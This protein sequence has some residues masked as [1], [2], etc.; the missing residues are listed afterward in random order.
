MAGFDVVSYAEEV[1]GPVQTGWSPHRNYFRVYRLPLEAGQSEVATA[2]ADLP[3]RWGTPEL[4]QYALACERLHA[5]HDEATA[6]LSDPTR[7]TRHRSSVEHEHHALVEVVR[8]RLHGAPA[9][10]PEEVVAL[11]RSAR[12]RWSRPDVLAALDAVGATAR[13]P[14]PMQRPAPPKRWPQLRKHLTDLPHGTLWDYLSNTPELDGVHTTVADVETRRQR[15]RVSRSR[16]ADAERSVLMLVRLWVREP[17]GLAAALA[18]ELV[19]DL[20]AAAMC[21]YPAVRDLVEPARCAAA[22]L[23]S[24]PDVVAYAAWVA[25]D[26]APWTDAYTAAVDEH[27]LRDALALLESHP[28]TESWRGVRDELRATI[29]RL[30]AELTWAGL[31]AH[32]A[33]EDA[34]AAYLLTG[35]QMRDPATTEGLRRCPAAPP[36]AV[37]AAVVDGTDVVVVWRPSTSTVGRIGYRVCRGAVV[38]AEETAESMFL[39][40]DAP[41]GPE[42]FY[43]V[44]ALREGEPGGTAVARPVTLRPEVADLRVTTEPG[45][46]LGRWRLPRGAVRA[47]VHRVGSDREVIASETGFVDRP[48]VPGRACTYLIQAEYPAGRSHGLEVQVVCLGEPNEVVDLRAVAEGDV[49]DLSWT[50]PGG[51]AVEIRVLSRPEAAPPGIVRLAQ[52]ALAG[53]SVAASRTGWARVPAAALAGGRT[54]VP[55]TVSGSVAAIGQAAAVSMP[56]L[57][58]SRLR[59]ERFG[60]QVLLTWHWPAWAQDV[61]VVWRHGSPP[62]GPADPA[63]RRLR[64]SRTAYLSRGVRVSAAEP[65]EHWF[66]V[67]VADQDQF[68]P[69]A[70]VGSPCPAQ[71]RYRVHARALSRTRAVVAESE[72]DLPEVVVLGQSARRPLTPDD[73]VVLATLP[74][75]DRVSRAE[76]TVP[77]ALRRPVLLRAFA[78]DDSVCMC[79]PDPRDLV[80]R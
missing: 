49:V 68:G 37:V 26:E 65:G 10:T 71:V 41:I 38:L 33:P 52:A 48:A 32:S 74:G 16:A 39:D 11:V 40:R 30:D 70:V 54:L 64:I 36:A 42:L 15:L 28:L 46:V 35:Q 18:H 44:T 29:A 43:A 63:A 5:C 78:L 47:V 6:V 60:P 53:P 21:G 23:P 8:H 22:G 9:M 25:R 56:V 59:A 7:R 66:G 14:D 1:A 72:V 62:T 20:A 61:L 17:G 69:L 73:G 19:A 76:F 80:V 51:E 77:P 67:C 31:V 34:A 3:T 55:V 13:E 2:L 45:V 79:H 58:V 27:R 24:D 57:R 12:G 4:R 50:P 75:G